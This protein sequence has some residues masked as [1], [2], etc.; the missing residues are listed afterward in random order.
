MW[1]APRP[2]HPRKGPDEGVDVRK[3]SVPPVATIADTATLVDPV[4]DNA[5]Q[6]P[7]A[8]A[9][10]RYVDGRWQEM[11]CT[12]FRDEIVAL[13]KGML[14]AGVSPGDRIGLMSRTRYEWTLID[15]AIWV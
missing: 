14:A 11:S 2:R 5:E 6:A 4:W 9:V 10:A 15:Y 12:Q 13:A 1:P 8:A 3:F 7:D